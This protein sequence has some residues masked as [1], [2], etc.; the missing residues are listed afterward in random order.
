VFLETVPS[1]LVG[2]PASAAMAA[3]YVPGVAGVGAS[4]SC[5]P[6][7]NGNMGYY[8]RALLESVRV[9]L[10]VRACVCPYVCLCVCAADDRRANGRA[11]VLTDSVERLA[12]RRANHGSADCVTPR[13]TSASDP[14]RHLC[15]GMGPTPPT[16]ASRLG[17]PLAT[18][19][20]GLGRRLRGDIACMAQV[21]DAG[22]HWLAHAT[23]NDVPHAH[24]HQWRHIG[25]RAPRLGRRAML[26]RGMQCD[27]RSLCAVEARLVSSANVV[28]REPCRAAC[29]VSH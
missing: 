21:P 18:A 23:P 8:C 3:A 12:D 16:I 19:A 14:G 13:P 20:S 9:H 28:R 11:V 1:P 24:A 6:N 27:W 7:T 26:L 15:A 22:A 2:T 17:S 5:L 29:M 4:Q 25:T 10:S